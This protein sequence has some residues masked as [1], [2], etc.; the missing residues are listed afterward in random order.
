M[1]QFILIS[2]LVA[3]GRFFNALAWDISAFNTDKYTSKTANNHQQ[4]RSVLG[5][6]WQCWA[7]FGNNQICSDIIRQAWQ[8]SG[9]VVQYQAFEIVTVFP[10][11]LHRPIGETRDKEVFAKIRGKV[12][13]DRKASPQFQPF[14][15]F[16]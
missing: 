4:C 11:V 5:N 1:I 7:R 12:S 3:R 8:C 15:I 16:N 14:K 2:L 6:A 13:I 9:E 10:Q